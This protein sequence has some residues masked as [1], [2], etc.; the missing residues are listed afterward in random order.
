MLFGII[1]VIVAVVT[2]YLLNKSKISKA[3]QNG[4]E[5][6]APAI[7]EVE[8]V[9]EKVEK[10]APK[11]ETVKKASKAVKDAKAVVKQ[12]KKK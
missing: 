2:I 9:I 7:E 5:V 10:V 4:K 6:I 3:I 1:I 8:E 11:N 12:A